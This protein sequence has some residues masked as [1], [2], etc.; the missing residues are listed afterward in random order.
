M[1]QRL[2]AVH[3]SSA[4]PKLNRSSDNQ[5]L[6]FV[7]T[8]MIITAFVQH[9]EELL[10]FQWVSVHLDEAGRYVLHGDHAFAASN[11][12]PDGGCVCSNLLVFASAASNVCKAVLLDW[13]KN[14]AEDFGNETKVTDMG[15]DEIVEVSDDVELIVGAFGAWTDVS[16]DILNSD[17]LQQEALCKNDRE[18][19]RQK[20]EGLSHLPDPVPRDCFV[21]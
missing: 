10:C 4:F 9:K 6:K 18:G 17:K 13:H 21:F 15:L 19:N 1:E 7:A 20:H 2:D 14:P 16:L 8:D 3:S 5:T 12:V 11:G